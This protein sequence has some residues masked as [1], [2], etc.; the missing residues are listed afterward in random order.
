[1]DGGCMDGGCV[2]IGQT[3]FQCSAVSGG[4]CWNIA[5]L[6]KDIYCHL[7]FLSLS[8]HWATS[9]CFLSV[10]DCWA[11]L[12]SLLRGSSWWSLLQNQKRGEQPYNCFKISLQ[13]LALTKRYKKCWIFLLVSNYWQSVILFFLEFLRVPPPQIP[14]EGLCKNHITNFHSSD[15]G[16]GPQGDSTIIL[17]LSS[18]RTLVQPVPFCGFVT[19]YFIDLTSPRSSK[20]VLTWGIAS[21]ALPWPSSSWLFTHV[22]IAVNLPWWYSTSKYILVAQSLCI[23]SNRLLALKQRF[24]WVA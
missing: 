3:S 24:V 16:A 15:E 11:S 2:D 21:T 9:G 22:L 23:T 5:P 19:A 10:S 17:D 13:I 20:G 1:M 6:Y 12:W 14:R 4:V 8:S 7:C 18:F